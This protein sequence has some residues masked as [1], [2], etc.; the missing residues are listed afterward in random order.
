MHAENLAV[1]LP[2]ARHTSWTYHK[3]TVDSETQLL[4]AMAAERKLKAE[5]DRTLK[6]VQEGQEVFDD[7]WNQARP[8]DPT[9]GLQGM[10]GPC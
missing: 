6:K 8:D 9:A 3:G 10:S 4:A 5:I 2:H 7:I 1:N